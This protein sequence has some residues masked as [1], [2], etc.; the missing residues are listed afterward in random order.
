[1]YHS[2]TACWK[3][4]TQVRREFSKLQSKT[5]KLNAV[6]EQHRVWTE[7]LAWVDL[8]HPWSENGVDFPP[9]H[10]RD[11]LINTILPQQRK[12]TIPSKPELEMPSRKHTQ[13]LSKT[14]SD[15]ELL[16]KCYDNKK[17]A[18]EIEAEK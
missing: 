4:A 18:A 5:A 12:C 13:Q 11:H 6:K 8:H 15:V 2:D 17:K 1:M 16:D 3:T 14:T 10:L 9:E 7:G